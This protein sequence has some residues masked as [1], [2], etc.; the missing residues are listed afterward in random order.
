MVTRIAV[1]FGKDAVSTP[2]AARAVY[3]PDYDS[4]ENDYVWHCHI[5]EHEENEMMQYYRIAD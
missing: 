4:G 1:P 3:V 2:V 5:L